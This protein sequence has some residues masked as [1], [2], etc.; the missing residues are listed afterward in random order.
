MITIHQGDQ[1]SLRFNV[2]L[3]GETVTPQTVKAIRIAAG[4]VTHEYP[5]GELLFDG[6][7]WLMPLKAN[8]TNRM[9]G[10]TAAQVEVIVKGTDHVH[11]FVQKFMV[12][13]SELRGTWHG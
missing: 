10:E 7:Y 12:N 8:E 6:T 5:S 3:N 13:K 1:L 11:S 9:L 2:K 4:H